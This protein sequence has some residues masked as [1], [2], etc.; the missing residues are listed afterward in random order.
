MLD[1]PDKPDGKS[2]SS[3]GTFYMPTN[4]IDPHIYR[5]HRY[6]FTSEEIRKGTFQESVAKIQLK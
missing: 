3:Y 5:A 4:K 1:Q 6:T 2:V